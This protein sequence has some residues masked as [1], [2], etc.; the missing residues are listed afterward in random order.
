MIA[1]LFS[2]LPPRQPPWEGRAGI[3]SGAPTPAVGGAGGGD[4]MELPILHLETSSPGSHSSSAAQLEP[5][6][7]TPLAVSPFL[8]LSFFF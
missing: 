8:F 3:G 1:E 7:G 5:V 4:R 2:A 6:A